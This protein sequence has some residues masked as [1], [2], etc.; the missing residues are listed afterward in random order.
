MPSRAEPSRAEPRPPSPSQ[1]GGKG[2]EGA[3][4]NFRGGGGAGRGGVPMGYLRPQRERLR[5]AE[6]TT[7]RGGALSLAGGEALAV[8]RVGDLSRPAPALR[9]APSSSEPA[10]CQRLVKYLRLIEMEMRFAHAL[11]DWTLFARL[12]QRSHGNPTPTF[13]K[14]QWIAY[15]L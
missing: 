1:S 3:E 6:V 14:S 13:A 15:S 2:K 10:H 9:A 12:W 5:Q 7:G 8:S 11:G 4:Y